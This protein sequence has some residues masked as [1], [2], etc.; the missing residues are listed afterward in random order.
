M[1]SK[2]LGLVSLTDD[3]RHAEPP[4]PG[5]ALPECDHLR[6][7]VPGGRRSKDWSCSLL[8]ASLTGA[9]GSSFLY[10]YN[11]SVVNAPT[12]YI[13]A[14]YNESW[15]RRHEHPI[16]PDT[17]TL[18]WSVT[19][20]IFAI[21]GLVGTLMVKMIGKVLGRKHTLLANNGFAISAALLMACSL[22]AGA[23]EMLIV[24][25]F[26]MGINGGIALSV[27]PMYLSEISPKQIRGSLGQVTAI[28]ICIGV[29][30]GQL[31]GLPELL[32]KESTW[33]YLFGVIA[34]PAVIQLL[35]LPFLPDSPCYLLLEKHNEA[36]A[37]KAFQTFLGKADVSREVEEVLADSRVQRNIRLVSV[38]EL[39]RAPY[40]RW[41]VVTVIVTMACYQLCGLN[42]IW[43]YTNS[44]FGNA[45]IPPANIPYVTLSTGGTETLAAIFSGLVIERLGRRPLLIG[46]FGLMAVFFGTLTITL[47]LQD[48]APWVPYLSIVCILAIIASFCSGPGGIPFI[49]TG[50]FFQQSQRPAAF[51][52]A[53]TVNWLS[54]FA[55]GLLFPFIQ[56]SLDTYCFLVFATICI[57]GATYLYFVLP[58]TKNRTHAEISQAFSKRNK[59]HPPE[60][61]IDPAVTDDKTN[62]RPEPDF[63]STLDNYVKNRMV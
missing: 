9:L 46:G 17:L 21:G 44:I 23:F 53:G 55:V 6:S 47:T 48:R 34:V 20:S 13:K 42:A 26:I 49:L 39:L 32:G 43:F 12:P 11:L 60:E 62:G 40:V 18:L 52:I 59:A 2:E 27:L 30:T 19:V 3:T 7:G 57:T 58:E 38:L 56:R 31:L 45:G 4:G 51:I 63:S 24:G 37:V 29:F 22:Q 54:N 36:R 61:K 15:Q 28:F 50:E 35:S 8:V 14:F 5:R 41:Q 1:N 10:G 25:R 33:P 16:D